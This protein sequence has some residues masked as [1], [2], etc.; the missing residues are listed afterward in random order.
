MMNFASLLGVIPRD[1]RTVQEV[2][3]AGVSIKKKLRTKLSASE[4]L[5][6]SKSAREGGSDKFSFFET[7][8]SIG[9]EIKSS[10]IMIKITVI[11]FYITASLSVCH[12]YVGIAIYGTYTILY[13]LRYIDVRYLPLCAL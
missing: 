7:T 1:A 4:Q 12:T 6:L 2:A 5:K 10:Q 13:V 8:G 11:L 3:A 9:A